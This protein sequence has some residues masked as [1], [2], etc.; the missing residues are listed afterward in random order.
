MSKDHP[1][2]PKPTAADQAAA[3]QFLTELRTRITTQP[4]PY[5][6]GVE[7]RALESLWEVFG[8]AREAMKKNPDCEQFAAR[9]TEMLN[10][11][12]R[13]LTAKWHR[14]FAEGRLNGRDGAD[15]FRGELQGVQKKLRAFA[16]ELH[17]M[18]YGKKHADALTPEVMGK[19]D[20]AA[21]FQPLDFGFTAHVPALDDVAA[22]IRADEAAAVR[23][24][25][26]AHG[27]ADPQKP[28]PTD[29]QDAIGLALSGGGIRSATFC[30][31]VVQV[32][33]E[34]GLLKE[35]DFLSTVSGGGYTGCF[36]TQQLGAGE[37]HA[38]VAS[39]HGPDPDA[40]RYVRQNARFLSGNNLK[41]RW[42]M[43]TATLAGLVLNWSGPLFLILALALAAHMLEAHAGQILAKIGPW[44][45]PALGVLGVA[46]T[47]LYAWGLRGERRVGRVTGGI[48]GGV[49]AV[50][51]LL[52]AAWLTHTVFSGLPAQFQRVA[53][54][55]GSLGAMGALVTAAVPGIIRFLPVLRDPARRK[56]WLKVALLLA[57]LLVP[58]MAVVGF[59][60][61]W[62]LARDFSPLL[63]AVAVALALISIFL[64][65]INLTSP[66]RLYRDG[67][68]RTFIQ[69]TADGSA[70]V[71]LSDINPQNTAPYHL[72]N[73]A[74]NVPGSATAGL[75]DRGCDF[76][77]FSRY[78]MGS[79]SAGYHRTLAW[80]TNG[81]D[82]D[83]A[84]AMAVS[85]AAFAPHMGLGSMPMLTALLTLLNV[86]LGFWI[87]KPGAGGFAV[88]GLTCLLRE[89]T[90]VGMSEEARWLHLSDGGHIENL[91][92]YELLRRRCKFIVCVD[93]ESDPAFT[94]HG[95]MTVVRHAQIDFGIHI[96][97]ALDDLRP[98]PKTGSSKCHYHLCR[99]HYPEG[100]G[101]L[102]YLKLSVTGNESELIRRYRIHNSD[103]PH[104]PTLDQFFD[105][106]QFEAYRQLGVHGAEGLFLPALLGG[107]EPRSVP[108]WFRQLAK[109]LLEPL[110][111]DRR[112]A[113]TP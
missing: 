8:Q 102:L 10:G 9:A 20:L 19:A 56:R 106:E 1:P 43:V 113:T 38:G 85:G 3:H 74:Q 77:F 51:G 4:L 36:L 30:L 108:E 80:Q 11:V 89:M 50:T 104:Q 21:L 86:R 66:H 18:A 65:N 84:T 16:G 94:F 71:R 111:E 26:K 52:G 75:K 103:F 100:V 54:A 55:C 62:A 81:K 39:P 109:N 17:E 96:T 99:I 79:A 64:L 44:V 60:A 59:Y 49:L 42:S 23:E 40:V 2:V 107:V 70:E 97:P 83:L 57:G 12:V 95:L 29:G 76:F 92:V 87:K 58:A 14:A 28:K 78:W 72:I 98:D 37:A 112:P 91:A 105:Q 48:L 53:K 25:R 34:R 63:A 82:V 6:H 5:Q 45:F 67:L 69:K 90:G 15:E 31:G 22:R 32:L 61:L 41:E 7:A 35:V 47:V 101:L 68:A 27:L 93:G 88:P 46:A 24:R 13:P 110:P 73:A 33:A